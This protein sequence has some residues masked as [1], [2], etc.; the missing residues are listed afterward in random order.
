MEESDPLDEEMQIRQRAGGIRGEGGPVK[1]GRWSVLPGRREK[2]E[3]AGMEELF[4][5]RHSTPRPS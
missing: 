4:G 1:V 5:E 3:G 2:E